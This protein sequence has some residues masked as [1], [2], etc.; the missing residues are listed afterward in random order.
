MIADLISIAVSMFCLY[1]VW[2]LLM[3][4]WLDKITIRFSKDWPG[5]EYPHYNMGLDRCITQMCSFHRLKNKAI[6]YPFIYKGR[7]VHISSSIPYNGLSNTSLAK[8]R[9]Q[10]LY[11]K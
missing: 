9:R 5:L 2:R 3:T 1:T 10:Y 7:R 11:L 6:Y 8:L 4:W